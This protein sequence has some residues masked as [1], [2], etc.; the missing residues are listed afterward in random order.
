MSRPVRKKVAIITELNGIVAPN[1]LLSAASRM[2]TLK[3]PHGRPRTLVEA[4]IRRRLAAGESIRSV[5]R[6]TGAG[7]GTIQRVKRE[8]DGA[9][10]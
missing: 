1:V 6:E 2:G 4:Q 8:M 9:R 3:K 7:S 5:I 10:C